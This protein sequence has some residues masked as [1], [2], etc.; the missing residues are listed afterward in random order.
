MPETC[1]HG[2]ARAWR[3]AAGPAVLA[4]LLV[5]GCGGATQNLV[6]GEEAEMTVPEATRI[7]CA[8][9]VTDARDKARRARARNFLVQAGDEG[10]EAA[11]RILGSG[12]DSARA[13]AIYI[14][15]L[16][17]EASED[18][19]RKVEY[20]DILLLALEDPSSDIRVGA[21]ITLN[22]L[23]KTHSATLGTTVAGGG[24]I[25]AYERFIER[26]RREPPFCEWEAYWLKA[27][28]KENRDTFEFP[29]REEY[30]HHRDVHFEERYLDGFRRR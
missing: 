19:D 20:V 2:P 10:W 14:M 9:V 1:C 25:E 8:V 30:G 12:D 4:A 21:N 17:V 13:E 28:W 22:E 6:H 23:L 18:R 3:A 5:A 7:I 26:A 11:C 15:D 29:T 27:W 24:G 16:I